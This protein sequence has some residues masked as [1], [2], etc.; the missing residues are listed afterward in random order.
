MRAQCKTGRLRDGRVLFN[1]HS[2]R[3]NTRGSE[4]RGY[5][6]EV[7]VF[8]VYCPDLDRVY[9]IPV[10]DVPLSEGSL[11]VEAPANGQTKG[12]RWAADYELPA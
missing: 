1:T 5:L 11:R 10:G 4:R 8:I 9:V 2:V 6:G 3:S 12:I 7:D